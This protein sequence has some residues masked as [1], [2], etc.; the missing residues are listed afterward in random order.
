MI[1]TVMQVNLRRL[2]HN[3]VELSLTF[4]VP[5]AFFSIFALIFGGGLSPGTTPK[6]KVI[7]VDEVKSELSR[8]LVES[9]KENDA[10]RFMRADDP[11]E[12]LAE[13]FDG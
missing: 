5:I 8:G 6:I 7:A 10:L 2:L 9:L 12:R 3:R 1:W 4:F 11:G 13:L